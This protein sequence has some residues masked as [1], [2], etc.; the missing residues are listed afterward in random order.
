MG[1][2]LA[3]Q[4]ARFSNKMSSSVTVLALCP[5]YRCGFK[6]GHLTWLNATRLTRIQAIH[7]CC[8]DSAFPFP[9]LPNDTFE[10]HIQVDLDSRA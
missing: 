9:R 2:T 4:A 6:T 8:E 7:F 3:L 10:E 5:V 1:A